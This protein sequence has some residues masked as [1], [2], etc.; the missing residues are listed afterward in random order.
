MHFRWDL[1]QRDACWQEPIEP[2]WQPLT[3]FMRQQQLTHFMQEL[4][5]ALLALVGCDLLGS[6]LVHLLVWQPP[7]PLLR[8]QQRQLIWETCNSSKRRR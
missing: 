7:R 2:G 3:H 6:Q 4:R 5:L 8:Q 1:V